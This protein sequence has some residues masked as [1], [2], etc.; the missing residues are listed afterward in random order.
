DSEC[1]CSDCEPRKFAKEEINEMEVQTK[2]GDNDST[3]AKKRK[4][5]L[6]NDSENPGASSADADYLDQVLDESTAQQFPCSI[7][8]CRQA[9][10]R[11][12]DLKMH[13]RCNHKAHA[14]QPNQQT[15]SYVCTYEGC[16]KAYFKP[17]ELIRHRRAHLGLKP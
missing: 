3:L 4:V 5:D 7:D 17:S 16:D 13:K 12:H 14:A 1:D 11:K 8:D 6:N 2:E 10:A 9:F 15:R